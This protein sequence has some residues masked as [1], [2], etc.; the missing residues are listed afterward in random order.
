VRRVKLMADYA[1]FPLWAVA[2]E[3]LLPQAD[4]YSWT[5]ERPS[6][7]VPSSTVDVWAGG[8]AP[9]GLPLSASLVAALQ[10]WADEHDR[11]LGP[12]FEWPSEE[13]KVAFVAHG[14]RL[15]ARVRAELGPAYEVGYFDEITGRVEEA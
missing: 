14:R 6:G 3:A 9:D 7:D 8:L 15:L 12:T 13:A 10:G 1:A 4:D 5:A 11:L 2:D